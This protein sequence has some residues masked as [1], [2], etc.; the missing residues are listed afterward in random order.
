MK[1]RR[2]FI[3]YRTKVRRGKC[4]FRVLRFAIFPVI[5]YGDVD[6]IKL[7]GCATEF[8]GVQLTNKLFNKCY[9]CEVC[10]YCILKKL[11]MNG[12]SCNIIRSSCHGT[13]KIVILKYAYFISVR[14]LHF[15][16]EKCSSISSLILRKMYV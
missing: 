16:E 15:Y 1:N 11:E 10:G 14:T 3:M 9:I 4:C 12:Y 8:F 7:L 5:L 13:E 2:D 6:Q